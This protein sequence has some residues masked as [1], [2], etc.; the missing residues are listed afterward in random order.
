[1]ETKKTLKVSALENGTVIDHIPADALFT[2]IKILDLDDCVN[3]IT[4][5]TN[6]DSKKFGKKGIIKVSNRYF[7][8]EEVNK[9]ALVA[10]TASLIE[11][12]NFE[13]TSKQQVEI[14]DVVEGYVKCINPKCVTN[15]QNVPRKFYVVS[16]QDLTLKCHYCEKFTKKESIQ[17]L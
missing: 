6:L 16:H 13:I 12:R 5:G 11:I 7:R 15:H 14:P 2:V 10:P 17:I 8:K 1:M 9:I 3:P 4:F